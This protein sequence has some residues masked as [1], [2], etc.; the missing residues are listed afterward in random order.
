M[1]KAFTFTFGG[2]GTSNDKSTEESKKG[3]FGQNFQSQAK[4]FTN[5]NLFANP[6]INST[7]AAKHSKIKVKK[8]EDGSKQR[9]E[10]VRLSKRKSLSKTEEEE[11]GE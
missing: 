3:P 8:E 1:K 4:L 11:K 7:A 9:Q 6:M 2:F 10:P 5:Q